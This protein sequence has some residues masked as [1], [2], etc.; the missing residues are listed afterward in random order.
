MGD[1]TALVTFG[2]RLKAAR[3]AQG[4]TQAE[5]AALMETTNTVVSR[6]END[7]GTPRRETAESL[8]DCL[9]VEPA[10]LMFGTGRRKA[11]ARALAD[12]APQRKKDRG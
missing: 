7:N 5:L 11:P 9:G 8:G 4:M 10:W 2:A 12:H 1:K 6:W 3:A